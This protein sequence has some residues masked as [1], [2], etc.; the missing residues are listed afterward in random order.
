MSDIK[1]SFAK[2]EDTDLVMS[3]I[4]NH[5]SNDHIFTKSRELLDKEFRW[6]GKKN[7]LTIALAW[8]ASRHIVGIF[9]FKFFK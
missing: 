1:F 4:S 6:I 9:C 7:S 5:W 8:D 3:F 2:S